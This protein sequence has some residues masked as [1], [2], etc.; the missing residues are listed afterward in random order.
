[1]DATTRIES[2]R[3]HPRT[4]PLLQ[5]DDESLC[6]HLKYHPDDIS[7]QETCQLYD[8][9]CGEIFFKELGIK[10]LI[11][12]YSRPTNVGDYVTQAKLHQAPGKPSS[13]I[14]RGF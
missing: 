4:P 10:R 3:S 7:R 2:R 9:H 5:S 12:A 8:Q 6:V 13:I 1:M 14:M 11:I